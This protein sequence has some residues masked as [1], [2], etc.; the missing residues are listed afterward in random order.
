MRQLRRLIKS[1]DVFAASVRYD[2]L[3]A[4]RPR[5]RE[6]QGQS[7][8]ISS[9]ATARA[10]A[11]DGPYAGEP[12]YDDLIQAG[13]GLADLLP[14]TD[15]NPEPRYMPTLLADKVSG[16]FMANAITAAL[17]HRHKTGEGQFVE[18]PML[19]CLVSFNLVENLFGQVF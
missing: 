14:R 9:T 11:R 16:L 3:K 7:A 17:F 15:G 18:V 13:S 6:R 4:P 19:E 5:L 8:R 2:G 12:A 1:C 10:T